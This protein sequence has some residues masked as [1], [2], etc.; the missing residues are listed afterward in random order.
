MKLVDV[1]LQST[2]PQSPK[3]NALLELLQLVVV[4]LHLFDEWH[5]LEGILEFSDEGKVGG[6]V[7]VVYLLHL[8]V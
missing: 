6:V 2:D 1:V 5:V 8:W 3:S 4:L 7:V